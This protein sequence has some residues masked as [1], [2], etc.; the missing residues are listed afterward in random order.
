MPVIVGKDQSVYKRTTCRNC[1]S[2][3]EYLPQE[4]QKHTSRDYGGGTDVTEFIKC[5][6]CGKDVTIRS[7]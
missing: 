5:P 2:I 3:L 1:A 4:V 7:W 6:C